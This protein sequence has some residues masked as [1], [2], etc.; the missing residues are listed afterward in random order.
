MNDPALRTVRSLT[1]IGESI[2]A[3]YLN[4][5]LFTPKN[6]AL[7]ADEETPTLSVDAAG[8]LVISPA[9]H[10]R[11]SMRRFSRRLLERTLREL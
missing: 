11:E 8:A 1:D 10:A 9:S 2:V 3:L 7:S 4:L 6:I 5:S